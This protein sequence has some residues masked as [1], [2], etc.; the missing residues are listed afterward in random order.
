M[1]GPFEPQL[2]PTGVFN[3]ET[4]TPSGVVAA[5]KERLKE[6]FYCTFQDIFVSV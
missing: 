6:K 2:W 3:L 1:I 5:S 4:Q